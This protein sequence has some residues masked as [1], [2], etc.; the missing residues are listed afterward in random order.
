MAEAIGLASSL[1]ALAGF[2]FQAS[3]SLYQVL[4]SFKSTKRTVRELRHELDALNQVIEE[5]Q[6]VAVDH[7]KDLSTLKLP[8]LRCGKTCEEFE[9]AIE[10][11]AP[12]SDVQRTRIIE[13]ARLQYMGGDISNLKATL[14]GYKATISIA[15]GGATL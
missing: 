15:L 9:D 10:K 11:C 2:A 1:A 14:S 12:R 7:E 5:L 6:K 3:K 13:W 4:E 8:L